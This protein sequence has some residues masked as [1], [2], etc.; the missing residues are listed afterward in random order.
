MS[1]S[2]LSLPTC[3]PVLGRIGATSNSLSP[4]CAEFSR[5][6]AG[7][8]V[9]NGY[10]IDTDLEYIEEG[11][12]LEGADPDEVSP[13]AIERGRPQPGD[14]GFGEPLF[15]RSSTSRRST[16]RSLPMPWAY[17]PDR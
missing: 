4:S 14:A 17:S 16:T 5:K 9:A 8:A 15:A 2:R 7:W 1:W 10:G 11:G 6:V 12:C 3:P 13:R